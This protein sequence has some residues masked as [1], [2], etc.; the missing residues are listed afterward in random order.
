MPLWLS[1]GCCTAGR[2]ARRN[3]RRHSVCY[4]TPWGTRFPRKEAA[5]EPAQRERAVVH[6]ITCELHPGGT[7]GRDE[8]FFAHEAEVSQICDILEA[9]KNAKG[10]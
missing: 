2:V 6:G 7:P 9:Y 1:R 4:S 5:D 3:A 10:S 8:L